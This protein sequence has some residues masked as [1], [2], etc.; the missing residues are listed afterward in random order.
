VRA[1]VRDPFS[2]TSPTLVPRNDKLLV[3]T[4]P[5]QSTDLVENVIEKPAPVARFSG[6]LYSTLL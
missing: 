5:Q 4:L 3:Y 1:A 2:E 6:L